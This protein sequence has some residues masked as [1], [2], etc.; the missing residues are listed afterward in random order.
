MDISGSITPLTSS[1]P[2]APSPPST[3]PGC[4][5]AEQ[6]LA[7]INSASSADV[8]SPQYP[9][10]G[11]AARKRTIGHCEALLACPSCAPSASA[12]LLV[13][14]VADKLIGA[15]QRVGTRLLLGAG[16]ELLPAA[17]AMRLGAYVLD[18]PEERASVLR[19]LCC[20]QLR[21]LGNVVASARWAAEEAWEPLQAQIAEQQGEKVRAALSTFRRAA[22]VLG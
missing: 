4:G 22:V 16:D 9:S 13:I 7:A 14:M 5:C 15:L 1:S 18:T 11:L 2:P 20:A 17:E 8:T 6:A 12:A 19:V 3:L 10:I 21:R